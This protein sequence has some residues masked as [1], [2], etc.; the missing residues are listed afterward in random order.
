MQGWKAQEKSRDLFVV[1][2]PVVAW[3][4]EHGTGFD[5]RETGVE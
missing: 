5:L 4:S 3:Y 1:V 2:G